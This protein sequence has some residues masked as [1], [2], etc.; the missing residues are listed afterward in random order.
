M[1]IHHYPCFSSYS[2]TINGDCGGE[3]S[4]KKVL[5]NGRKKLLQTSQRL[6]KVYNGLMSMQSHSREFLA[7]QLVFLLSMADK[8]REGFS[9]NSLASASIFYEFRN[10]K[11][12]LAV[13][14]FSFSAFPIP[15]RWQHRKKVSCPASPDQNLFA[16]NMDFIKNLWAKIKMITFCPVAG[17]AVVHFSSTLRRRERAR[18]VCCLRLS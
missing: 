5:R 6:H 17:H 1:V 14:V 4:A 13:F 3:K 15:V 18:E 8:K 2:T 7:D 11:Y 9:E 12:F 16:S 10:H